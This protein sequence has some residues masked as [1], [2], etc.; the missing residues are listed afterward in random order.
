VQV[1]KLNNVESLAVG[2]VKR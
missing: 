2:L 1:C